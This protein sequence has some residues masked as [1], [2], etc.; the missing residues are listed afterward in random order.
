M[1]FAPNTHLAFPRES[2][3]YSDRNLDLNLKI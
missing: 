1:S 2:V 3:V